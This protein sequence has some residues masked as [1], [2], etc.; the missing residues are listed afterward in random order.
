MLVQ[1]YL[2]LFCLVSLCSVNLFCIWK[3]ILHQNW[4]FFPPLLRVRERAVVEMR[5]VFWSWPLLTHLTPLPEIFPC[6]VPNLIKKQLNRMQK[7][8]SSRINLEGKNK[9][10][11]AEQIF[12]WQN[13]GHTCNKVKPDK[14]NSS[15]H[16]LVKFF[17]LQMLLWH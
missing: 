7:K 17:L 6:K 3:L 4:L 9:C 10:F 11:T 13:T 12:L 5:V 2:S 14:T 16:E 1:M 15:M 8:F